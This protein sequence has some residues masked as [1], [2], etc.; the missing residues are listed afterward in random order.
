MKKMTMKFG[1]TSVGSADALSRAVDIVVLE[2]KRWDRIVVVVSAMNGVTDELLRAA[3]TAS[4]KDDKTHRQIH[5]RI[6]A[7]YRDIVQE[8]V[9]GPEARR[10]L[11]AALETL[12]EI[13]PH[14]CAELAR[15]GPADGQIMDSVASLGERSCAR[16]FSMDFTSLRISP[17]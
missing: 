7:R 2:S 11:L 5:D 12:M 1:G 17:K 8:M 14:A 9:E 15:S 3:V 6:F 16:I 13:L 4:Q 10:E